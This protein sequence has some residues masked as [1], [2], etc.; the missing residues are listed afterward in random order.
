MTANSMTITNSTITLMVND[1]DKAINFYVEGLGLKL[2]GR[3]GNHYSQVEA[4]GMVIGLHPSDHKTNPTESISIGFGVDN[5]S[6]AKTR[7][8]ELSIQYN[9]RKEKGGNFIHF[10]DPQGYHLYFRENSN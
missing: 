1:M 2:L 9:E 4:S 3:Y 5:L 6:T 7:L 10:R 8:A